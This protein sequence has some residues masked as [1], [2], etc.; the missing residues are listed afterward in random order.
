MDEPVV[1]ETV[2]EVEVMQVAKPSPPKTGLSAGQIA[3]IGVGAVL[4]LG[5]LTQVPDFI[6]WLRMNSM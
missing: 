3:G 4:F 5:V 6:R 1:E 2:V